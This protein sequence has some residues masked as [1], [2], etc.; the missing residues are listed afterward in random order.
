MS[1]ATPHCHTGHLPTGVTTKIYRMYFPVGVEC[2]ISILNMLKTVVTRTAVTVAA[3]KGILVLLHFVLVTL[4]ALL[5]VAD[6]RGWRSRSVLVLTDDQYI[7]EPRRGTTTAT[8]G[9]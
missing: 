3:N 1:A 8:L 6:V 4:S 5:H 9:P 2:S 7:F